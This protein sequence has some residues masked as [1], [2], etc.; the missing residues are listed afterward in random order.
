MATFLMRFSY[1]PETWQH[2]M[3]NPE[4]RSVAA[5]EYVEAMGGSM[6]GFW[7][8]FGEYDGHLIFD[9]PDE[10]AAAGVVLAVTAGGAL[11]SCDTTV[12]MTV[13]DTLKALDHGHAVKYRKPGVPG[14]DRVTAH[15]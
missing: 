4:D 7:Y 14:S 9:A 5:R 15:A 11:S 10:I 8:S 1:T 3:A 6:L 13:E 2:L 12:L